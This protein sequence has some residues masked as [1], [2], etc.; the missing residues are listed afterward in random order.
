MTY[1]SMV[2]PL[3]YLT[4]G[5]MCSLIEAWAAQPN[6]EIWEGNYIGLYNIPTLTEFRPTIYFR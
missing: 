5:L 3:K 4:L 2:N 6:A 1:C